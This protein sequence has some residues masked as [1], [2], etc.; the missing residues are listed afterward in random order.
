MNDEK[1][2]LTDLL[3][4]IEQRIFQLESSIDT[5]ELQHRALQKH[6][7]DYKAELDKY[8]VYNFHQTMKLIDKRSLLE[9]GILT[10]LHYQKNTPYFAK[11]GFFYEGDSEAVPFY[12]GRYGFADE[13]G[14]QVVYDWRASVSSL[15]Y[16]YG[17]GEAAYESFGRTF[18]GNIFEKKQ[19]EIKNGSIQL[20]VDTE[21]TVNDQFLLQELSKTTT[22]EMKNII[23]TIQ[24]EQNQVIRETKTKNLIIQ[25]VA[26]SGK[27]SIALHRMAY[28][29]YQ[30]RETLSAENM[31]I[32]SPSRLFS[33][34]I[35][36]V[37]PELGEEELQ[38]TDITAI[39]SGFIDE[40]IKVSD[41]QAELSELIEHPDS[42]ESQK[43]A[44]K[45]SA[46]YF[47]RIK[48]YLHQLRQTVLTQAEIS[49]ESDN[50]TIPLFKQLAEHAE[51]TKTGSKKAG[52]EQLK[53]RLKI[54]DSLT[55]YLDFLQEL[56][57]QY[58]GASRNNYLENSDLFPY[59]MFKL[60]L[61]GITPNKT[62]QHFVIDEMQ[63]YSV[64]QFYVLHRLFPC[65]KTICGDYHQA[66][67]TSEKNFLVELK[68]ILPHHKLI[69]FNKSYRSTVEIIE[70][71]KQFVEGQE[72]EAVERHGKAVRVSTGTSVN[73]QKNCLKECIKGFRNSSFNS[74]GIICQTKQELEQLAV[75]LQE[76]PFSIVDEM[77]TVTAEPLILTTIQFAKGLEFDQ[78]ILPDI[79]VSQLNQF[80]ERLYT[81][82]TRALHQLDLFVRN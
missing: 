56:P 68:Q 78:V 72:L 76:E 45:S 12:I 9:S 22:N 29:L 21:E 6:T 4:K 11:I 19:F 80:S 43:I 32:L 37:L 20:L 71:A 17:L 28:L 31:L 33:S 34:Y 55:S 10:K 42:E 49:N 52:L 48:E 7:V 40:K 15:Y 41:R 57:A 67:F 8:E 79:H 24:K 14:E 16:E 75:L 13:S 3:K 65:D 51:Q 81:S 70:F 38:Q 44:Y 5:N 61:E 39:G 60:Q 46:V 66:I 58:R 53:K 64:L 18:T 25:G 27:T 1:G 36:S 54:K 2:F 63:D 26:G 30:K 82:C 47:Q 59:L 50:E 23:Q 35:S 69:E 62:I 77:T 73:E 74:C